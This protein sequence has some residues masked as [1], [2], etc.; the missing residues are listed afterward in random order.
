MAE[1]GLTSQ[2]LWNLFHIWPLD[3]VALSF[4]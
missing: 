2:S 4:G 3:S 1:V